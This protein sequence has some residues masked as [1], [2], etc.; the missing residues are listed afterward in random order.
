M[1]D[2]S[3]CCHLQEIPPGGGSSLPG[4][5]S[6]FIFWDKVQLVDGLH[7]KK[8]RSAPDRRQYPYAFAGFPA[9]FVI[10]KKSKIVSEDEGIGKNEVFKA[11]QSVQ[12]N[13]ANVITGK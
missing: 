5:F 4:I 8:Y 2:N 3:D 12:T 1:L 6:S 10:E 13:L 9:I 7:F 11:S